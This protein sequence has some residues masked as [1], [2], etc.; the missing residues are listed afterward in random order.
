MAHPMNLVAH[1]NEEYQKRGDDPLSF[2]QEE[3]LAS[4]VALCAVTIGG[5]DGPIIDLMTAAIGVDP[6]DVVKVMANMIQFDMEAQGR[7]V[8]EEMRDLT[9]EVTPAKIKEALESG[10]ESALDAVN[11]ELKEAR[12]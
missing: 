10:D 5:Q 1:A 8:G 9:Y 2:S 12:S 7:N 4:I 3:R 6:M 11:E